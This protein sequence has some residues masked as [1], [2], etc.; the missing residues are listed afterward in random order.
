MDKKKTP[1]VENTGWKPGTSD[2]AKE[3]R[4][5]LLTI[6]MEHGM[7]NSLDDCLDFMYET[8][9]ISGAGAFAAGLSDVQATK[10]FK[11]ALE[12]IWTISKATVAL[13][14]SVGEA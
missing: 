3:I 6:L 10:F 4:A 12:D 5:A 14:P 2:T 9:A 13:S 1:E 8:M 7:S 11:L